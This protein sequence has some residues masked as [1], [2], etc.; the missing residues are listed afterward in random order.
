[1][2]SGINE[3]KNC[4]QLDSYNRV[5]LHPLAGNC[6]TTLGAISGLM[7]M[8]FGLVWFDAHGDYNTPE[9]TTSGF[10]WDLGDVQKKEI[11]NF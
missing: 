1:M 5:D 6:N 8:N 11:T 10:L 7:P 9:T 2:T 4:W 3:L